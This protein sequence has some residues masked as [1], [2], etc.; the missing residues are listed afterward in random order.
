MLL[1]KLTIFNFRCYAELSNIPI[2]KL[3]VFIG[4]NDAG[5]TALLDAIQILLTNDRPKSEHYRR[6]NDEEIAETIEIAGLFQLEDRDKIP[7]NFCSLDRKEFT[8]IKKF[9]QSSVKC[10]VLGLGFSDERFNS[11]GKQDAS[12]QKE[13]LNNLGITPENNAQKRISQFEE[14]INIGKINRQ[15]SLIETNFSTI[16]EY[17]PRFQRTSSID[18][19]QPDLIVRQ[20]L[21]LAI[22]NCLHVNDQD[23]GERKLIPELLK[24]KNMIEEALNSEVGRIQELLHRENPK[25][26]SVEVNPKIE[27]SNSVTETNLMID[28]GEGLQLVSAFGD[29]TRKKLWM[30]LLNWERQ[31]Q[32]QSQ[33]ISIFQVD[34]DPDTNLDYES[35]RRLF[36]N[37]LDITNT[38]NSGIQSV[39]CT[40]AVTMI[41]R[42]PAES[43]NLI[44]VEQT[45]TRTI[46]YL[47]SNENLDLKDFLSTVGRSVGITNSALFYERAFLIVEGESEENALP[48]LYYNLYKRSL[49]EDGIVLVCLHTCGAWRSVLQVFQRHKSHI[50]VMLLD[51]DCTTSDANSITSKRLEDIGYPPAFLTF[52]CFYIGQKEFE[53]AFLTNDIVSVLNHHYP[54]EDSSIWSSDHVDVLRSE[55]KFSEALRKCVHL[56]GEKKCRSEMSKPNIAKKIAEQCVTEKQIPEK[57]REAFRKIRTISGCETC[58]PE[59]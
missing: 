7:D 24:V 10:E 28:I 12:T 31:V 44:R 54:R 19:K 36:T 38:E 48:I 33:D 3:T 52:N 30:G 27:F 23:T 39:I 35:E 46:E 55:E 53:D 22:D 43:I 26:L 29:G 6:I 2:H 51:Q 34:D 18:Y 40:H 50:T 41:D 20:T 17:L 37:I 58:T 1:K 47:D 14:A 13:L 25:L 42:A 59:A 11:F 21:R 8:L 5:K 49:I 45:G 4:E 32:K 15:E 9:T 16:I 57:I 56:C